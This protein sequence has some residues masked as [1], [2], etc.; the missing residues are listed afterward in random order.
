[1]GAISL[2]WPV[3][4]IILL[5]L[6]FYRNDNAPAALLCAIAL[7][8]ITIRRP[9]VVSVLRIGLVLGAVEW[10]RTT[11]VLM[12]ARMEA[13]APFVRLTLI[14]GSAALLT[15]ASSLVFRTRAVRDYFRDIA[16][17]LCEKDDKSREI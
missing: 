1:M 13:G 9:W 3:A 11:S 12:H 6:H 15:L 16:E 4:S 7:L 10:G 5:A 14:L 8:A 17:P 2:L